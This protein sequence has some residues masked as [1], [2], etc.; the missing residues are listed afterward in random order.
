[1]NITVQS[2][3]PPWNAH[4]FKQLLSLLCMTQRQSSSRTTS[5]R[6]NKKLKD[7]FV[8]ARSFRDNTWLWSLERLWSLSTIVVRTLLLE[9]TSVVTTKHRQRFLERTARIVGGT[10]SSTCDVFKGVSNN[11]ISR[12]KRKPVKSLSGIRR[13]T[14]HSRTKTHRLSCRRCCCCCIEMRVWL[15]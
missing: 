13:R 3:F 1:M 5:I 4:V 6:L 14:N 11:L 9:M 15:I 12:S 7:D 8:F 2:S 10:R